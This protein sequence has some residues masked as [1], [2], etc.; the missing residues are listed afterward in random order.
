MAGV[1]FFTALRAVFTA[2]FAAFFGAA[3]LGANFFFFGDALVRFGAAFLGA[4]FTLVAF[5]A[6]VFFT[7][8][9]AG[10]FFVA[11]VFALGDLLDFAGA[12]FAIC[13]GPRCCA[14]S[15]WKRAGASAPSARGNRAC[16]KTDFAA[17]F[18]P[19]TYMLVA[20][21]YNDFHPD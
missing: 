7:G 18:V 16:V 2:F 10:A 12:F 17:A 9:F 11:F 13:I 8:F 4:A 3:L 19:G 14:G 5:F 20:A 21:D 6:A 1:A 15:G